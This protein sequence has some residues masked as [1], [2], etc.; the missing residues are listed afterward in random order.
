MRGVSGG[1]SVPSDDAPRDGAVGAPAGAARTPVSASVI[2]P[3]YSM[4][5]W[6][7]LVK[8]V[9]SCQGQTVPPL[10]VIL[11]IDHND[12]LLNKCHEQWDDAAL[13][14]S[15][16]IVANRFAQDHLDASAHQRAHGSK[17]RFG[18][19]WA[20]NTGAEIA[21]GHVLVF[22]DDDAWAEPDWLEHLLPPYADERTVAVGGAP[23]PEYQTGR[24]DWFPPNFDWVF[25]CAYEGLPTALGP[26]AHLIGANMSVRREAF[27][28][29]EGFHSIDFDDL[30]LCMRVADAFPNGAV[31][32]EPTAVVHHF[33]PAD[34]VAFRYFWRRCFF[35]NREKVEAFVDMGPAANLHAELAFVQRALTVQ[36]KAALLGA[37]RGHTKGFVQLAVMLL[38]IG[39]A[40][41]GNLA[42]RVSLWEEEHSIRR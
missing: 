20:R 29:V 2:I 21:R 40:G 3:A 24:P 17:R 16:R 28:K 30:D 35:V 39:M 22:L 7:Q 38:G 15:I 10:E 18:A 4:A 41:L 9:D 33:V 34:R 12:E 5:R 37:A 42:G 25:G 32:Y 13:R 14:A 27:E 26:L 1:M 8:A 19:G 31:L 11:C 23:L 6:D 36:T